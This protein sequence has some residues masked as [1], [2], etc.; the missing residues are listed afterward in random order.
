MLPTTVR[1]LVSFYRPGGL[2]P[3]IWFPHAAVTV[4]TILIMHTTY[5]YRH[6][7]QNKTANRR[8]AI[9]TNNGMS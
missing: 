6:D 5:D 7:W 2:A 3:L 8:H 4:Y 9:G 1:L